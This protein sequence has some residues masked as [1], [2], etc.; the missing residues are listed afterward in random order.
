MI[1]EVKNSMVN[2][3]ETNIRMCEKL[4]GINEFMG[5]GATIASILSSG[6]QIGILLAENNGGS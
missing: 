4:F 6:A 3:Q 2:R 1:F 5:F